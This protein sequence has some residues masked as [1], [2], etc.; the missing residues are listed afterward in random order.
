M[1][2]LLALNVPP[3]QFTDEAELKERTAA[4]NILRGR[5]EPALGLF[6]KSFR[7]C[8]YECWRDMLMT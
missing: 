6:L 3:G 2:Y 4:A 1:I 5:V 8:Q 7:E